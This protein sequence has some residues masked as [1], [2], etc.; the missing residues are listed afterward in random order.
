MLR[1]IS[2]SARIH[3]CDER[4]HS[5][6]NWAAAL[7]EEAPAYIC[8]GGSILFCLGLEFHTEILAKQS[9]RGTNNNQEYFVISSG[10]WEQLTGSHLIS[11]WKLLLKT[12]SS[13]GWK[14]LIGMG[15]LGQADPLQSSSPRVLGP[16]DESCRA[17]FWMLVG[18]TLGAEICWNARFRDIRYAIHHGVD[19][20]LKPR[21]LNSPGEQMLIASTK[22]HWAVNQRDF[23]WETIPWWR[24]PDGHLKALRFTRKKHEKT[25]KYLKRPFK[26]SSWWKNH[27]NA[28]IYYNTI[29]VNFQFS[30]TLFNLHAKSLNRKEERSSYLVE[31]LLVATVQ[32]QKERTRKQKPQRDTD[33]NLF[34]ATAKWNR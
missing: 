21:W 10:N 34:I 14:G 6:L 29:I 25:W 31:L 1:L 22:K 4:G 7:R 33:L 2:H 19:Q 18:T 23:P 20:N 12:E 28:K 32:E 9:D 8:W 17:A 24:W 11:I 30:S 13:N 16:D 5:C 15:K 26:A 3:P 27:T